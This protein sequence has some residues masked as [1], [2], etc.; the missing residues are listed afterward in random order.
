MIKLKQFVL[1]FSNGT[2]S[3]A[4]STG[5]QIHITPPASVNFLIG[6]FF[7]FFQAGILK[8]SLTLV[9]FRDN[10]FRGIGRPA[11][12]HREASSE[13]GHP[14]YRRTYDEHPPRETPF[15]QPPPPPRL[16]EPSNRYSDPPP[17]F[18]EPLPRYG[19]PPP[20]L[21]GHLP[22]PVSARRGLEFSEGGYSQ[23]PGC[24]HGDGG[25]PPPP[26]PQFGR[27][28]G[29]GPPRFRGHG[30]GWGRGDFCLPA[31]GRAGWPATFYHRG[32]SSGYNYPPPGRGGPAAGGFW[33]RPP[34]PVATPGG[35]PIYGRKVNGQFEQYHHQPDFP[36][37]PERQWPP[38]EQEEQEEGEEPP[39]AYYAVSGD[40]VNRIFLMTNFR[41]Q[42][43]D[44]I[45]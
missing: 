5:I 2:G 28:G 16:R 44:D 23:G 43:P 9:L 1:N 11:S 30:G 33:Q 37:P 10:F 7:Y 8:P 29:T 36:H 38:G 3:S 32:G 12:N 26:P 41:L 15:S 27:G 4:V 18:S 6:E 25:P 22:P 34:P 42:N 45:P 19:E 13:R 21:S 14:S 20:R 40:Q 35:G 17:R 31:R 39:D 24:L